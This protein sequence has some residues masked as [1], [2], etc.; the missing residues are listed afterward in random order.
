MQNEMQSSDAASP[1]AITAELAGVI[2]EVLA[3]VDGTSKIDQA[4]KENAEQIE[5][6]KRDIRAAEQARTDADAAYVLATADRLPEFERAARDADDQAQMLRKRLDRMEQLGASLKTMAEGSDDKVSLARQQLDIAV[7][8]FNQ[9]ILS[10]YSMELTRAVRGLV[11]VLQKGHAIAGATRARRLMDVLR[12][13]KIGDPSSIFGAILEDGFFKDHDG[14][15]INLS[16]VI[17]ASAGAAIQAALVPISEARKALG[18]YVTYRERRMQM[19]PKATSYTIGGGQKIDAT[20][21]PAQMQPAG[22]G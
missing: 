19:K 14:T 16:D 2:A 15:K 4:T 5:E 20:A 8:Q 11:E 10:S 21:R 3:A 17:D 1:Y 18:S 9:H 22:E 7:G 13:I 6:L 12:E